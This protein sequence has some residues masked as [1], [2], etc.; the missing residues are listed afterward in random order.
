MKN[1]KTFSELNE[2]KTPYPSTEEHTWSTHYDTEQE[3]KKDLEDHG[4]SFRGYVDL[5]EGYE[6]IFMEQWT[7]RSQGDDSPIARLMWLGNVKMKDKPEQRLPTVLH[8]V[9][10]TYI[11]QGHPKFEEA[12]ERK[13]K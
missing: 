10:V 13:L 11:E 1:L 8:G 4:Y 5:G 3:A 9:Q 7:R 2:K 6:H 12:K